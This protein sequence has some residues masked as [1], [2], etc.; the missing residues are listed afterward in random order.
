MGFQ[1]A[2]EVYEQLVKQLPVSEQ[3]R[4]V[5]R[6]AHD[7]AEQLQTSTLPPEL[8]AEMKSWE[9][10]SDEDMAKL[11]DLPNQSHDAPRHGWE[12]QFRAAEEGEP[13]PE[14][15]PSNTMES[16]EAEWK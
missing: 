15:E 8:Q 6:I 10:A 4:L 1:S 2:Q 16:D 9:A 11:N 14:M 3:L 5:E 13:L 7:L 12:A